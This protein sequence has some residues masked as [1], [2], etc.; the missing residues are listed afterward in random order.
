MVLL[1]VIVLLAVPAGVYHFN[2]GLMPLGAAISTLTVVSDAILR[3]SNPKVALSAVDWN[4][5]LGFFH[6]HWDVNV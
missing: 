2:I 6:S 1:L 3:R 4:V 5:N